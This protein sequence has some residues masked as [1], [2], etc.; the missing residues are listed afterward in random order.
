MYM[1]IQHYRNKELYG[2]RHYDN[3]NDICYVIIPNSFTN[4]QNT[5]RSDI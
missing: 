3:R 4:D 5:I 2:H 1:Y